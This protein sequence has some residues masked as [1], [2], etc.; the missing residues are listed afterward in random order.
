MNKGH[1]P[2]CKTRV[3]EPSNAAGFSLSC[4]PAHDRARPC[5]MA[6]STIILQDDWSLAA[7]SHPCRHAI[8]ARSRFTWSSHRVRCAPL[9]LMP[10]WGSLSNTFLVGHESGLKT[11]PSHLS[12]AISLPAFATVRLLGPPYSSASSWFILLLHAPCSNTRSK[13][14]RS[15]R[16]S[17]TPRAFASSAWMV[18]D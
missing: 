4:W 18:Q 13:M 9:R 12:L 11:C 14:V 17:N 15:M 5:D 2:T 8:S 7:A 1:I 10:N 6:R 3:L 16:H